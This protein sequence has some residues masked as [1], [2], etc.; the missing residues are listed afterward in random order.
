MPGASSAP[1]PGSAIPLALT[2]P[3][4]SAE[5]SW[6]EMDLLPAHNGPNSHFFLLLHL[7]SKR[8]LGILIP[9]GLGWELAQREGGEKGI[10]QGWTR[11]RRSQGSD[12][13]T[14]TPPR[15]KNPRIRR[16]ED[17]EQ[18]RARQFFFF[19]MCFGF[20]VF[21]FIIILVGFLVFLLA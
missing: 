10:W 20:L 12:G 18:H 6:V 11:Q 14:Q 4:P 17:T 19:Q 2:H 3:G 15:I 21:F 16:Q 5:H 9:K 8:S 1:S 7:P 13:L